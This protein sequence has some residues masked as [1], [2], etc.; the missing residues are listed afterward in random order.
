MAYV[1]I[2]FPILLSYFTTGPHPMIAF[3]LAYA[4]GYVGVLLSPVHL[5]L[6]LTTE[7]FKADLSRVY[8][9]VIGPVSLVLSV[10]LVAYLIFFYVI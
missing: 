10:A 5:C 3:M 8:K 6:V 4:G 1:G 7:Y 2:T 9:E